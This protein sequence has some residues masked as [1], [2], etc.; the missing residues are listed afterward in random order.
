MTAAAISFI[1]AGLLELYI[2]V[3]VVDCR[4]NVNLAWQVPQYI[5]ISFAEVLVSVTVLEFAYSQAPNNSKNFATALGFL[6]QALGTAAM[7]GLAEIPLARKA[8]FFVYS[9]LMALVIA[10]SFF[11]NRNFR[12]RND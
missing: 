4:G 6:S 8:E 3:P 11:L 10:V 2:E 9:G 1:L 12:Y 5:A 7:A